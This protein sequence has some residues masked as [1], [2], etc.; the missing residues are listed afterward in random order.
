MTFLTIDQ[1][2]HILTPTVYILP[3]GIPFPCALAV[4]YTYLLLVTCLLL[5]LLV[6]LILVG[7]ELPLCL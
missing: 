7:V 3:N 6:F 4:K 2:D 5:L 1:V